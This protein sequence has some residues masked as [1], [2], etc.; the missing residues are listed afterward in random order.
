MIDYSVKTVV[1]KYLHV[2]IGAT[3]YHGGRSS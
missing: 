1:G 3:V 2:M